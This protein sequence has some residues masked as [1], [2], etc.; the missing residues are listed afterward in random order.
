[1]AAALAHEL[2][3]SESSLA[4]L[5]RVLPGIIFNGFGR[6]LWLALLAG[7]SAIFAIAAVEEAVRGS[8]RAGKQHRPAI[9]P[10]GT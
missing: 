5:A 10:A 1:L 8:K 7:G 2:L 3:L 4:L 9:S 6:L